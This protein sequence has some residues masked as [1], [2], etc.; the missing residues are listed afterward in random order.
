MQQE[1]RKG[2]AKVAP[3]AFGRRIGEGGTESPRLLS[4]T[5]PLATAVDSRLAQFRQA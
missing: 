5:N 2:A 3:M 4:T 1:K